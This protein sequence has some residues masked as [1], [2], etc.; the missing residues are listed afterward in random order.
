MAEVEEET[1]AAISGGGARG[2][3]GGRPTTTRSNY[4]SG[5]SH[6]GGDGGC[7]NGNNEN[8]DDNSNFN[9]CLKICKD[10]IDELHLLKWVRSGE[11]GATSTFI[12]KQV[13]TLF[14]EAYETMAMKEMR[15]L[16]RHMFNEWHDLYRI[17]I[18]HRIGEVSVGEASVMIVV[19]GAHRR[20]AMKAVEYCIDTLKCTVPIWKKEIYVDDDDG[21]WKSNCPTCSSHR[22]HV[23]T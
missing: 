18:V 5:D 19:S 7:F 2:G 1:T 14:Y 21:V 3:C 13:R 17:A 12:G 4:R 11:T 20:G 6:N 8:D 16:A 23:S 22:Q 15:K 10:P 9:M